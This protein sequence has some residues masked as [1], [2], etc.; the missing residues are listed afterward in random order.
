MNN[1]SKT[2]GWADWTF[3]PITGCLN[4]CPYCYARKIYRR[5]K[6]SFKPQFH[7][8]RLGEPYKLRKPSRI[9][10]GSTT[11]FWSQGVRPEW[12]KAVYQV[13]MNNPQHQYFILTKRP[14]NIPQ[15]EKTYLYHF[16]VGISVTRSYEL[17]DRYPPLTKIGNKIFISFE[18]LLEEITVPKDLLNW[19]KP[20]WVIIG[21]LTPKLIHKTEWIYNLLEQTDKANIPVYIKNNAYY[22]IIRKEFPRSKL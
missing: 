17:W 11:D 13:L 19:R 8:D 2:I 20:N 4:G 18:P 22:P 12:R 16:F 5:F 14:D 1:V 7:P 15:L 10:V 3:N 6:K 21:G 9:F